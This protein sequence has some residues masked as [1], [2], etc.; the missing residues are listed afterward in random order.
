MPIAVLPLTSLRRAIIAFF[1]MRRQ[2]HATNFI[3]RSL[4]N[5]TRCVENYRG[6]T[7]TS[8]SGGKGLGE[9]LAEGAALAAGVDAA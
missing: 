3:S 4:K 8:C 2:D 7:T 9:V 6:R 5:S 1:W